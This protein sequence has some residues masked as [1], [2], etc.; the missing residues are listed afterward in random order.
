MCQCITTKQIEGKNKDGSYAL[1]RHAYWGEVKK[2]YALSGFREAK[3]SG[4]MS[5]NPCALLRTI[6]K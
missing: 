6:K 2:I 1:H 5:T 3:S 4:K